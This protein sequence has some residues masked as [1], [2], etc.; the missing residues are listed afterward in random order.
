MKVQIISDI[1]LDLYKYGNYKDNLEKLFNDIIKPQCDYLFL[2]GDICHYESEFFK[3][4]MDYVSNN[5]KYILYVLGNHE[6][7]QYN[8]NCSFD[9]LITLYDNIILEY[10]N[11]YL[12][13]TMNKP[14]IINDGD[15]EYHIIG[16]TFYPDLMVYKGYNYKEEINDFNYIYS[17]KMNKLD[18]FDTCDINFSN[19]IHIDKLIN[20]YNSNYNSNKKLI[21]MTHFPIAH[22]NKV[23]HERFNNQDEELKHYF[24]N[25]IDD[26]EDISCID[27]NNIKHIDIFIAGH[28]HY[29][30]DYTINQELKNQRF[31]SNQKGYKSDLRIF[32][33]NYKEDCVIY[34]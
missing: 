31:I 2:V 20:E 10:H 7:Y 21:L 23:S 33:K 15:I 30:Y 18:I 3:P 12:L 27:S 6:Y 14:F 1:H 25:D 5:W 22:S 4:F 11:I 13:D 29:S 16:N 8:S 32:N 26:I 19:S 17:D 28:T 9:Y 34:L 24:C